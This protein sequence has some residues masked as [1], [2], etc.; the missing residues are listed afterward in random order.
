MISRFCALAILHV[1]AA[2]SSV[3]GQV[4]VGFEGPPT[5]P[6]NTH[7]AVQQ[8]DEHGFHFQPDGPLDSAPPYRMGRVGPATTLRPNNGTTHLALLYG[9]SCVVTRPDGNL[10]SVKSIQIAEYS[11]VVSA[12]KT[13]TF[14]GYKTNGE[15]VTVQFTTDGIMDGTG[16]AVDFQT[17]SFPDTFSGLTRLEFSDIAAY[18]NLVLEHEGA[19]P[20]R[21]WAA[22][23]SVSITTS[24]QV[25]ATGTDGNLN[26]T[27]RRRSLRN[28]KIIAAAIERGAIPDSPDW[29]LY[30]V[31]ERDVLEQRPGRWVFEVRKPSG[32]RATLNDYMHLEPLGETF[33]YAQHQGTKPQTI[34]GTLTHD[35]FFRFSLPLHETR[36]LVTAYGKVHVPYT[37]K[38]TAALPQARTN[39]GTMSFSGV[40]SDGSLADV[41]L[42]F[43]KWSGEF[44]TLLPSP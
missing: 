19:P 38:G 34:A 35:I 7:F 1:L 10:F 21:L 6:A 13:V 2:L 43:G 39:L 15:T 20:V 26:S 17:F 32:E 29:E 30:V 9:D 22:P 4:T 41:T 40:L 18:D 14:T 8:Y 25:P 23:V 31:Y 5:Q 37:L 33:S 16:P 27:P 12:A 28:S 3:A 36:G 24:T 11:T 44:A 42:T